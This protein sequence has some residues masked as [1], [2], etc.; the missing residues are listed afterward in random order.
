MR[1]VL[2]RV[3]VADCGYES[4]LTREEKI[5]AWRSLDSAPEWGSGG[6][7]FKSGRPD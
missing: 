1:E 4:S 3:I 6:R 7:R 5:G 2:G